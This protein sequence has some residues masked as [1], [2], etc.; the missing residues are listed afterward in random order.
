MPD[1]YLMTEKTKNAVK[2]VIAQHGLDLTAGRRRGRSGGF[3]RPSSSV[4]DGAFAVSQKDDTTVTVAAGSVIAGIEEIEVAETDKTISGT[5]VLYLELT[6]DGSYAAELIVD[7]EMPALSVDSFAQEIARITFA[8][9]KITAITQ[10]WQN[11][12][13]TVTGRFT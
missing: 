9:S 1:L 5:C 3:S 6:Y 2:N 4:Y 8:D 13:I 10:V 12:D 11:D 7:T